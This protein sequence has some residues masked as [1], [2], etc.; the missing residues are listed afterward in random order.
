MS[1]PSLASV[2]GFQPEPLVKIPPIHPLARLHAKFWGK[3]MQDEEEEWRMAQ[4]PISE[5][6][7]EPGDQGQDMMDV[8]S[9]TNDDIIS[10]CYALK[11]DVEGLVYPSIWIRADYKRIYDALEEHYNTLDV[12]PWTPGAVVTGQ[13][14]IGELPLWLR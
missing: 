9:N 11:I 8:D 2:V 13:P 4:P 7:G 12:L 5:A 1:G 3:S 6:G 14:G 10:G